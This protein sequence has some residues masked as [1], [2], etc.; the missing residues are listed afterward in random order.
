MVKQRF[1][2]DLALLAVERFERGELDR[3]TLLKALGA[4][5]LGPAVLAS[6]EVSAQTKEIVM[7][8]Y[9]GDAVRAWDEAWAQPFAADAKIKVSVI[10]GE[11][12]AG[13]IKAM[14]ESG[15]IVWDAADAEAF[16]LAILGRDNLI[17]KY[18]YTKVDRNKVRPE[19]V[20]D[21]G[22]ASYLYSVVNGYNAEKTG[23]RIP[24]G[25][26]DFLNFKDFPGKRAMHKWLVGALEAVLLGSGVEPDK[27]YPLDV[28]KAF[29]VLKDH[30]DQFL[31]WGGGAASQ[32]LFRDGEVV[33]GN[34][35]HTRA[36][37]LDRESKGKLTWTWDNGIV[38]PG[39]LK[40]P[41]KNPAGPAVFDL[42]ASIQKPERQIA[43]LKILG[44]SPANPAASAM[45]PPDLQKV[46]CG[47]E[48]NY[49]RQIPINT[50]WYAENYDRVQD[51]FLDLMAS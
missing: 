10:G 21:H 47:Y 24:N 30:K 5:A 12:T 16:E 7:V 34:I 18:D 32:Q 17:Q 3:R 20:F 27:L 48:P 42:I 22:C 4:L 43:L 41:V 38:A 51:D 37:V 26:K 1:H 29:A 15:K 40:V 11:P 36:S 31:L 28:K 45:L 46:D 44:N 8:N 6:S 50:T 14:V 25:Y 39:V 13:A 9:G 2:E 49:K 33:M 35:W 23:G 19:F